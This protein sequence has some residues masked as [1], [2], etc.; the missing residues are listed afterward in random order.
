YILD[1]H[2]SQPVKAFL[3]PIN[4]GPPVESL[5]KQD[6]RN[7]LISAQSSVAVD[8]SGIDEFEKTV[9][10]DGYTVKLNVVRPK[11]NKEKIPVF[12]FIHGGGWILGDYPTHKRLVRDLVVATG[13]AAVFVNYTPSP[14]ARYPQAINEIYAAAK[15]VSDHGDEINVDGKNLAAV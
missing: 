14:E 5:S 8:L 12:I 11:G 9:T 13:Y 15:W 3:K 4:A 2:L 6:A 7:V 1:P 10:Q